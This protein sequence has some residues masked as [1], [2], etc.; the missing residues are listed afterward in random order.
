MKTDY[1][2]IGCGASAMSFVDVML[3]ETDA[4]F[5]IVDKRD[6]PG[7]HWNDATPKATR[8]PC[9]LPPG[10]NDLSGPLIWQPRALSA[11]ASIN[12]P[13]LPPVPCK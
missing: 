9:A 5:V 13:P 10:K 2:V 8:H 3:A 1:L 11:G 7:G 12:S 6:A 4:T